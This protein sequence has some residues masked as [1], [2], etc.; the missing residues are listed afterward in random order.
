MKLSSLLPALSFVTLTA[1]GSTSAG[2]PQASSL[3]TRPTL[4]KPNF[5][6]RAINGG[7]NPNFFGY[8]INGEILVGK[9]PCEAQ[10]VSAF[11]EVSKK[12]NGSD[13]VI[14]VTP[15]LKTQD[16][17]SRSC[18]DEYDPVFSDTTIEIRADQNLFKNILVHGVTDGVS[19]DSAESVSLLATVLDG[20]KKTTIKNFQT[21]VI[22]TPTEG[23]MVVKVAAS[24]EVGPNECLAHGRHGK[25]VAHSVAGALV[26]TPVVTKDDGAQL[27]T[28]CPMIYQ[29]YFETV[30]LTLNG[31][32]AE[33]R[34]ALIENVHAKG[35][36]LPL[37]SR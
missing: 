6:V 4:I 11:F 25:L 33:L 21:D 24:V 29:P 17:N 15:K 32:E 30:T 3:E 10:G 20:D 18:T 2:N 35:T 27:M 1:C 23:A 22:E 34:D 19:E 13:G 12:E 16:S 36:R 28:L 37:L 31:S 8:S 14:H 7:I 9:N 5:T 26:V